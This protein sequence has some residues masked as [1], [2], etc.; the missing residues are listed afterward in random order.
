[1]SIR[2]SVLS[3]LDARHAR[4]MTPEGAGRGVDSLS[5]R[6]RVLASLGARHARWMTTERGT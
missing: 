3:S 1:M 2:R 5:I 6:C 4:W